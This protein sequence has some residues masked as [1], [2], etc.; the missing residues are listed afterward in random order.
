MV[1]LVLGEWLHW[2]IVTPISLLSCQP[3]GAKAVARGGGPPRG[4]PACVALSIHLESKPS[5]SPA[6]PGALES[7]RPGHPI[8]IRWSW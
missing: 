3:L 8:P 5:V 1:V 4:G 6:I 2:P 7:S